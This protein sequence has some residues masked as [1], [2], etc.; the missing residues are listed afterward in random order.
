MEKSEKY[1]ISEDLFDTWEHLYEDVGFQ[2]M[3]PKVKKVKK[4][5]EVSKKKNKR[6]F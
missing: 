6:E 5:K 4:E 2:K 1:Q 3:K